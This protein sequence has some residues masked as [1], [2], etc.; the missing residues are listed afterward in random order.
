MLFTLGQIL[1]VGAQGLA[2]SKVVR[3]DLTIALAMSIFAMHLT[4]TV[5]AR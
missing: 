4:I 5:A 1:D 2:A 3:I